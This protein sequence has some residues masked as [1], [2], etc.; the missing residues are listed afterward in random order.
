MS[1]RMAS[2]AGR[3]RQPDH[4]H[5]VVPAWMRAGVMVVPQLTR[6][7]LASAVSLACDFA[8]YVCLTAMA[9]QPALAGAMGYASGLLL[10][11]T[12]SVRFVFDAAGAKKPQGQLFCAFVL[13]GL[14]GIA[15][16][17]GVIWLAVDVAA[18]SPLLAKILATGTSFPTLFVLRRMIVFARR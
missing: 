11:Y 5:D 4:M 3:Y 2:R 12:L 16:T 14:A 7:S 18:A 9:V 6:Y 8:L 1:A 17:S 13:S 15:I 10:H